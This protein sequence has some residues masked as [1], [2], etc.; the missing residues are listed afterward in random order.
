VG[1]VARASA[2][3]T[4]VRRVP[5]DVTL[6]RTRPRAKPFGGAHTEETCCKQLVSCSM[7]IIDLVSCDSSLRVASDKV[8]RQNTTDINNQ[9]SKLGDM[10]RF[11]EP[12]SGQFLKHSNGTFMSPNL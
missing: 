2:G 3:E 8:F 11:I 5:S 6:R 1:K 7:K 4:F 12:F 9:H 10:F